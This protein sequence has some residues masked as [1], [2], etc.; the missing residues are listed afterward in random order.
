MPN[1]RE[2]MK[3]VKNWFLRIYSWSRKG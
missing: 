3:F 1:T 2:Q